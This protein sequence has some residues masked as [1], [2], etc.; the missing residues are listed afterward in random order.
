MAVTIS[1]PRLSFI[2]FGYLAADDPLPVNLQTDVAFQVLLTAS[3]EAIADNLMTVDKALW[4]YSAEGMELHNYLDDTLE[5]L[6]YRISATEVLLYWANGLPD[7]ASYINPDTCFRLA[8]YVNYDE[9]TS[10]RSNTNLLKFVTDASYTSVLEYS[11]EENSYGFVYCYATIP[12][13]VRLPLYLNRPQYNDD[14]TVYVKSDGSFKVT[15]SVTRKEYEVKTDY[16][17]DQ[18]H[19]KLKVALSHDA[20]SITSDVYSGGIRKNGSYEILWDELP[21]YSGEASAKVKVNSTPYLVRNDNC[22]VCDNYEP[23]PPATNLGWSFTTNFA[24]TGTLIITSCATEIVTATDEDSGFEGL[25]IGCTVCAEVAF[26]PGQEGVSRLRVIK[27]ETD[28]Y[29]VE[30]VEGVEN[31]FCFVVEAGEYYQI[32]GIL[33]GPCVPVEV[34]LFEPLGDATEGEAYIWEIPFTGT[35]PFTLTDIVKPDWMTIVYVDIDNLV[36]FTGTPDS[37]DIGTGITVSF[38]VN[39]CS[40]STYDFS[41]TIDVLSA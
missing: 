36:R 15:R 32:I 14:E 19:E 34:G 31:S 28:I 22:A 24:L 38:T 13:R 10:Y 41:D 33:D 9:D 8:L 1:S 27:G 3:S 30:E 18:V 4:L 23:P 21:G 16:F 25:E 11:C 12:N 29:N 17:N 6:V 5:F 7:L 20:V 40:D 35:A 26:E 39:N 2:K 37:G